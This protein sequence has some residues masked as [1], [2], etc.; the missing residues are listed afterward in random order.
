VRNERLAHGARPEFRVRR[1]TEVDV[2]PEGIADEEVEI[3]RLDSGPT[4]SR[5]APRGRKHGDLVHALLAHASFPPDRAEIEALATV[6]EVGL[7]MEASAR[8][9]AVDIVVRTFAH[10]LVSSALKAQRVHREYP[11][12]Y[13]AKG[14]FHEGVIDLVSF[15]GS[16][17][18]VLDYKTGPGD[19][20]RYRR[21]IALYGEIIRKT[22]A[23]PVRLVVLEI[24]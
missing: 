20:P 19:E 13:D 22:T 15:D 1:I 24:A 8:Q 11:V 9:Q 14:E 12:T 5:I 10:P 4:T 23:A 3:L 16:R 18:T 7:R 2:L 17:W 21:Q 6:H